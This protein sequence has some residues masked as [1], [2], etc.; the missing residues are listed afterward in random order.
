MYTAVY[1]ME[2]RLKQVAL[3]EVNFAETC[4]FS[5]LNQTEKVFVSI[6]LKLWLWPSPKI[7]AYY[8]SIFP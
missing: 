6:I 4:I 7:I 8:T 1:L 3:L 2:G 5:E